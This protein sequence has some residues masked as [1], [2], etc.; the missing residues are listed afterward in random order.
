MGIDQCFAMTGR[1]HADEAIGPEMWAHDY[2][3]DSPV[4]HRLFRR[5][6]DGALERAPFRTVFN[7]RHYAFFV[8]NGLQKLPSGLTRILR[9]T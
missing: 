5:H 1:D 2:R 9:D 4:W 3:M 8:R 6:V 7:I